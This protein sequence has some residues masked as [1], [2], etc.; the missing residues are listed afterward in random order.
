MLWCGFLLLGALG[1]AHAAT[2]IEANN[3]VDTVLQERLPLVVRQSPSLFPAAHIPVFNFLV[4]S[5]AITNR[6]LDVNMTEGMIHGLDTA[7]RR[8]GDCQ[9]RDVKDG[10]PSILCTLDLNEVNTTFLALTRGDNVVRSLKHIW[11]HAVTVDSIARLEI[12][13]SQTR[14]ASLRAF[15]VQ[16]LH[17]VTTYDRELHLNTDRSRQFKEHVELKVKE[18][19]QDIM[20]NENQ[21]VLTQAGPLSPSLFPE[22]RISH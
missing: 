16:N 9:S 7:L 18:A 19:L 2:V 11:V 1:Y 15:D 14:V 17:F 12:T 4:P 22:P 13:G 6:D 3:F 10:F 21:K 8:M 20:Q 5:N